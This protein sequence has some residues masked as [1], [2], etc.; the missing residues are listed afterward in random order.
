[1]KRIFIDE[2]EYNQSLPE[3][4]ARLLEQLDH[5]NVIKMREHFYHKKHFCLIMDY[6]EKGKIRY[7]LVTLLFYVDQNRC[8]F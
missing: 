4:E 5:P 8:I 1:M 2:R 6:A 3:N 7:N